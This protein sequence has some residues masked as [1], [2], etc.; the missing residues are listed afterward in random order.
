M[1]DDL[2]QNSCSDYIIRSAHFPYDI[3]HPAQSTFLLLALLACT[4]GADQPFECFSHLFVIE[5]AYV[6][7]EF[8]AQFLWL[9]SLVRAF[10]RDLAGF[11]ASPRPRLD[12][13]F[14]DRFICDDAGDLPHHLIGG[15]RQF[16]GQ[17]RAVRRHRERPPD[18]PGR[19]AV[20]RHPVPRDVAPVTDSSSSFCFFLFGPGT[21]PLD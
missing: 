18:E 19:G 17:G 20:L 14:L 5:G 15:Q 1:V 4:A 13:Y 6:L 12:P 9:I 8:S 3:P 2:G 10:R 11:I 16:R 7:T 21:L